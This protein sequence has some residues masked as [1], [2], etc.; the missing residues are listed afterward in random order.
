M[1]VLLAV[2]LV[3]PLLLVRPLMSVLLA[4]MLVLPLL[5]VRPLMSVLLAV[6]LLVLLSCLLLAAR[7]L[8]TLY[9][10]PCRGTLPIVLS[11]LHLMLR[12]RRELFF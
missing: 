4:V 9:Y 3:L 10:K 6:V 1:S 5:L 8:A 12:M 11:P 7:T 2:V